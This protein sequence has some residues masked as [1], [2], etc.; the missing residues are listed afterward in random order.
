MPTN[1]L[2]VK[3][4]KTAFLSILKSTIM[5]ACYTSVMDIPPVPN[6]PTTIKFPQ[7]SFGQKKSREKKFFRLHGFQIGRGCIMMKQMTSRF[8]MCAHFFPQTERDMY[9]QKYFEAMDLVINCV[10]DRFDQPGYKVLQ[11]VKELLNKAVR[12]DLR[13]IVKNSYL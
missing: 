7:R 4:S 3:F 5:R 12:S 2:R 10:K 1:R 8:A 9:R 11:N 13:I 6:Q